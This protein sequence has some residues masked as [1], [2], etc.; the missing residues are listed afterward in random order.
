MAT[1]IDA[2]ISDTTTSQDAAD[3]SIS[4]TGLSNPDVWTYPIID[5]SGDCGASVWAVC[6]ANSFSCE[7]A[8][9]L[10]PDGGIGCSCYGVL[11]GCRP[12]GGPNMGVCCP[13]GK[14]CKA[15]AICGGG[16]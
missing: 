1:V 8:C 12:D 3:E 2:S 16:H 10:T 11:G 4:D 9:V 15:E 14:R 6:C 13:Y 5:A 7:G